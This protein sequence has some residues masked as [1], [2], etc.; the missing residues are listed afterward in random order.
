VTGL[1]D[2]KRLDELHKRARSDP[3]YFAE[4]FL[5]MKPFEYQKE[6]LRDDSLRVCCCCGR[7][8]GKTTVAAVKALHF[9]YFNRGVSVIVVSSSL[10]QSMILFEKVCSYVESS[11]VLRLMAVEPPTKTKLVFRNG[12][13]MV[14]LPCGRTGFSL[15]GFTADLAV[16]DE[17]N[18]MPPEVVQNVIFPMIIARP[19]GR[20]VMLSTP[21][22][23]NHPF[24]EAYSR[25]ELGYRVYKWPSGMSPLVDA[26]TLELY[27]LSMDE[28]SYAMEYQAEFVDEENAYFPSSLIFK[29][30]DGE[31]NILDL[32]LIPSGQAGELFL[33]LDLGK[34]QDYSVVAIVKRDG[35]TLKLIYLKQFPLNTPYAMVVGSIRNLTEKA[36]I[37]RGYIDNTG[38]GAPITEEIQSFAPQLEGITLTAKAKQE[39]YSN[40]RLI[41]EQGRLIL[42]SER[43]LITQINELTYTLD[44]QGQITFNHPARGHDDQLTALT[45]AAYASH[46]TP[47]PPTGRGVR[48]IPHEL[49]LPHTPF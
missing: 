49:K 35:S 38:L 39:I 46:S 47:P 31:H 44:K 18:F 30:I 24:Y 48:I 10:R 25:Q 19:N 3:V 32:D 34:A 15:R 14:A 17:A 27:R 33:G 23:K 2:L 40:L 7:Q 29:C 6:F 26:E 45:L 20:I 1:V 21:W 13:R 41:M 9:T 42:P 37:N 12:S 22:T 28:L 43:T 8:V 4:R 36:Y 11:P 5:K 16:L